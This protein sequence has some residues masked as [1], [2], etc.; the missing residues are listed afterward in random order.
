MNV[1]ANDCCNLQVIS[2]PQF[3]I[4]FHSHTENKNGLR[5]LLWAL[6]PGSRA[7]S[8]SS[9]LLFLYHVLLILNSS[10]F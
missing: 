2:N 1:F 5:E 8:Q 7:K 3:R 6:V 4:M 9:S 10:Y